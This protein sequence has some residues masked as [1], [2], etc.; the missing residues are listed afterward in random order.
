MQLRL[1]SENLLTYYRNKYGP[2]AGSVESTDASPL[3]AALRELEEETSLTPPSIQLFRHGKPYS[4][5]DK[6]ANRDWTINPFGFT[7]H[8]PSRSTATTSSSSSQNGCQNE[9]ASIRLDWE[10]SSYQWFSIPDAISLSEAEGVPNLLKSLRR[11]LFEIDLGPAAG[12]VLRN[13]LRELQAD[14]NSGARQLASKALRIFIDVVRRL[15]NDVD[16][17]TWWQ[18]VRFAGWHL[19]KNGRE[20]MGASILTVMLQSFAIITQTRGSSQERLIPQRIGKIVTALE[21]YASQREE[22][23][24]Q[25]ITKHL[26]SLLISSQRIA[27]ASNTYD[28][29]NTSGLGS[30]YQPLRILTLLSTSSITSRFLQL[31]ESRQPPRPIEIHIL[32]AR[33]TFKGASLA[34]RLASAITT[35]TSSIEP[36]T[37]NSSQANQARHQVS[38]T[39]HTDSSVAIASRNI[40]Y[41]LL[42]ADI[43]SPNGNVSNKTGSL[44][45][46]LVAKHISPKVKVIVVAEKEKI[47]PFGRDGSEASEKDDPE[48]VTKSC[49]PVQGQNTGNNSITAQGELQGDESCEMAGFKKEHLGGKNVFEC[50]DSNLI[51]LYITEEG[52]MSRKEIQETARDVG[53]MYNEYLDKL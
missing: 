49:S 6:S 2:V 18:N 34:H 52:I 23:G 24:Y 29:T 39:I 51:D 32:E 20:S 13:G 8:N 30:E 31:L 19:W 37:P 11:V 46:I 1:I 48:E 53:G 12:A 4:F 35:P 17:E 10:H 22:R 26:N 45:A 25:A 14:H 50:V 28:A 40:D 43:I 7:L 27:K 42:D 33:L 15:D 9:A 41:L 44:P 3:H 38:I 5:T 21:H 36:P 47:T 16:K